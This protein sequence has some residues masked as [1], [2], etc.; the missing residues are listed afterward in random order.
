LGS[1]KQ[2]TGSIIT[3]LDIP[4]STDFGAKNGGF[5][6]LNVP[7][8]LYKYNAD[9]FWNSYNKP[10][11]DNAIARNDKIILATAPTNDNLFMTDLGSGQMYLTGFGQEYHY[12]LENG[13]HFDSSTMQMNKGN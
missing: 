6:L 2:D 7:D 3:E 5:T 8:D 13:Y 1:F 11:I 4:K 10:W 9:Q 12:L